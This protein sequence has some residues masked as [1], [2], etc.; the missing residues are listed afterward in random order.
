MLA[1]I[2]GLRFMV[3]MSILRRLPLLA[4]ENAAIRP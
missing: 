3:T 4:A 1:S 2:D